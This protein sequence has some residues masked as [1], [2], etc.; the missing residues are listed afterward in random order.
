MDSKTHVVVIFPDKTLTSKEVTSVYWWM[1][2]C[3][4]DVFHSQFSSNPDSLTNDVNP[5]VHDAVMGG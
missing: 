5:G 1:K 3:L 4:I 2:Q